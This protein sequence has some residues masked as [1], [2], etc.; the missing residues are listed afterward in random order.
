MTTV[1][2][3]ANLRPIDAP[4]TENILMVHGGQRPVVAIIFGD[5][6]DDEEKPLVIN[7]KSTGLEREQLGYY[8]HEL[9][10][11]ILDPESVEQENP[12]E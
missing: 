8:L 11:M 12:G 4:D 2:L 6:Y 7:I 3:E 9:S 5:D 1:I 10:H